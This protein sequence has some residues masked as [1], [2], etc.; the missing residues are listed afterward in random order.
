MRKEGHDVKLEDVQS[1]VRM[2]LAMQRIWEAMDKPSA[3]RFHEELK[4]R[5]YPVDLG[6][7]KAFA[8]VMPSGSSSS[9]PQDLSQE[10]QDYEERLAAGPMKAE[11]LSLI[12]IYEH[13]RT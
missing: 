8:R 4:G 6:A 11:D 5:N 12:Q 2:Q 10:I 13:T 7:A 3:E 9:R 1:F